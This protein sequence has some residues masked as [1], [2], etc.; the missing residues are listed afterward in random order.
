M[1]NMYSVYIIGK[2]SIPQIP[3]LNNQFTKSI[4]KSDDE[5]IIIICFKLSPFP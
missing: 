3:T 2:K 4:L 1:Y 5:Y